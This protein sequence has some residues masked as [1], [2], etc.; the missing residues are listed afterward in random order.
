MIDNLTSELRCGR[1]S[2]GPKRPRKLSP[3]FTLGYQNKCFCPER[4]LEKWKRARGPVEVVLALAWG[5]FR[6]NPG[7]GNTQGKPWAKLSW[8]LRA[9]Y[10]ALD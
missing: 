10:S 4:G 5:P 2:Y 8:P 1:Q 3:G 9:A 7:E 6:A